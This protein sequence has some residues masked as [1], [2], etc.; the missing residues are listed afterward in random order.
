MISEYNFSAKQV[1]ALETLLENT[2]A[3]IGATQSLAISDATANEVLEALPDSIS[4]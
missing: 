1:E 2:D 3:Y 4:A